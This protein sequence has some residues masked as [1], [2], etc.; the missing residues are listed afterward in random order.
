MGKGLH[1]FGVVPN[2]NHAKCSNDESGKDG[3]LFHPVCFFVLCILRGGL[4]SGG[5]VA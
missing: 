3:K 5:R 1:L 2:E 4:L